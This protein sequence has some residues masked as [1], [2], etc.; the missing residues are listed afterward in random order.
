MQQSGLP[1]DDF[2][3][4]MH[5]LPGRDVE[6]ETLTRNQLQENGF[7]KDS[8][9]AEL[10]EWYSAWSGRSPSV[11][12]PLVTLFA[13]THEAE[14]DMDDGVGSAFI[15]DQVTQIAE[16]GHS[17]N[18]LC[19]AH[20]LGLKVF[21]L[22]LQLPVGDISVGPALDEKSC[23]GTIAFGMEA[24]A[25]GTDLL[26]LSS[27]E[28]GHT[29]SSLAILIALDFLDEDQALTLAGDTTSAFRQ[30]LSSAVKLHTG[31]SPDGLELLR[32]L[33]GRET[34][35]I[36]GAILAARTQHVPVI[37][38]GLTALASASLIHSF[39][40]ECIAHCLFAQNGSSDVLTTVI[41]LL[42]LNTIYEDQMTADGGAGVVL[43]GGMVR[44]A[45]KMFA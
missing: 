31:N 11:N 14:N 39:E 45:C 33:G 38:D 1:F 36:Y 23:A 7:G 32:R 28:R 15:L 9:L 18:R 35:A 20:D 27:I 6:V 21:D 12:R 42:G 24:I 37:L 8:K 30:K 10:C 29:L 34:A 16:G 40:E 26:C 19:H 25:G 3:D 2:R 13:G 41:D 5:S 4:L 44:S 17:T 43:A 22:A